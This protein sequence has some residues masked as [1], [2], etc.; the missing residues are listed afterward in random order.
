MKSTAS[1]PGL[2]FPNMVKMNIHVSTPYG[3][4]GSPIR[5]VTRV[6]QVYVGLYDV[7]CKRNENGHLLGNFIMANSREVTRENRYRVFSNIYLGNAVSLDEHLRNMSGSERSLALN[8]DQSDTSNIF[9][10]EPPLI[11]AVTFGDLDVV[12]ARGGALPYITYTGM[13][14]PTGS[15]F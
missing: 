9:Q 4:L 8:A 13:C 10:G 7:L 11:T 6:L 1:E 14:R 12:E 15:G 2:R 3:F 5:A